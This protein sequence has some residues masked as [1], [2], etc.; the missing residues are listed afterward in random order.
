[1]RNFIYVEKH[2]QFFHILIAGPHFELLS[3]NTIMKN[4]FVLF[5]ASNEFPGPEKPNPAPPPEIPPIGPSPSP[6]PR[7]TANVDLTTT[8]NKFF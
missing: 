7:P 6:E 8:A 4:I 3:E 1:M 2:P 5:S